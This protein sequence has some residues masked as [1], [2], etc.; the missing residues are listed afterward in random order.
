[1]RA[2]GNLAAENAELTR[3]LVERCRDGDQD[4]CQGAIDSLR[5]Q[6]LSARLLAEGE[7]ALR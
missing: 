5:Q 4:A 3:I 2:Y 6:H 1:M 7:E